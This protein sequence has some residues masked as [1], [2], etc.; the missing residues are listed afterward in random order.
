MPFDAH[1]QVLDEL[2][3]MV[4]VQDKALNIIYLNNAGKAVF[5]DAVGQKCYAAYE[6][7]DEPCE[8]CGVLKSFETEGTVVVL[9]TAIQSSGETLYFEN[10]CVPLRDEHGEITG[11]IEICRNITDRVS[12]EEEV[13][14][15]NVELGQLN[16][17]LKRQTRQLESTLATLSETQSR[18]VDASRRAGMVEV[19]TNI[20]HN[21]GNALNGVRVAAGVIRETVQTS[22]VKGLARVVALMDQYKGELGRFIDEHPKGKKLPQYLEALSHGLQGEQARLM[23][24]IASLTDKIDQIR[25]II[26]LQQSYAGAGG[27]NEVCDLKTVVEDALRINEEDLKR[28]DISVNRDY[29]ELPYVS[30]DRHKVTIVLTNLISNATNAMHGA[31]GSIQVTT[32][33]CDNDRVEITVKDDGI[34]I[35]S[36]DLQRIFAHGFTTRKECLGFGLHSAANAAAEMG[37]TLIA[38]SDGLGKG[39]AFKLEVPVEFHS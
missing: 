16:K 15:R 25:A 4:T 12:L 38:H 17:Q 22:D 6:N 37:G 18:L 28:F 30:L 1:K 5:G 3:D 36:G 35:P 2:A 14:E 7:R 29:E 8:G 31:P 39:A 27:V 9:R 11:G 20:L 21:A 13:K 10:A 34:G 19:A 26:D 23:E 32:K 33:K 24:E